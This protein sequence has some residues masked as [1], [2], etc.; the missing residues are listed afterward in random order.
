MSCYAPIY[1][2][3][4]VYSDGKHYMPVP[5]GKCAGCLTA[6][7]LQWA[8]RLRQEMRDSVECHFVTLTYDDEHVPI[9]DDCFFTLRKKDFQDFMKRMRKHYGAILRYYAVGE[10]GG[11][12]HRP[13]YHVLLFWSA[14]PP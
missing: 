6:S 3:D 9:K 4:P 11:N 1:I 7:R 5:C 13:H 14:H 2:V 12:F 8:F 10:Y